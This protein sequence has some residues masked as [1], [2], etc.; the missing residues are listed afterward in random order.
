[1]QR[2]SFSENLTQAVDGYYRRLWALQ[3]GS[4]GQ[5]VASFLPQVRTY[6]M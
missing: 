1:M 6:F 3:K 4:L 5:E 2:E